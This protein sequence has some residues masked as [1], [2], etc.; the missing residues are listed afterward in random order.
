VIGFTELTDKV[1]RV[2]KCLLRLSNRVTENR[3]NT[4][5]Q[6]SI[7]LSILE[8]QNAEIEELQASIAQLAEQPIC[9]RQVAGS[10]PAAGSITDLQPLTPQE[11][12]LWATSTLSVESIIASRKEVTATTWGTLVG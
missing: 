10:N 3:N 5:Y 7:V 4:D 8:R 1:R 6:M 11:R 9:N 12:Y 2:A